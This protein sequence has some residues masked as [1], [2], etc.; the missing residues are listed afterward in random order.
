M[1]TPKTMYASGQSAAQCVRHF[2]KNVPTAGE[3]IVK[4]VPENLSDKQSLREMDSRCH[5][6][7]EQWFG[8]F[9]E[10]FAKYGFEYESTDKNPTADEQQ[11]YNSLADLKLE[12]ADIKGGTQNQA[13]VRDE[14]EL[15]NLDRKLR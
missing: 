1:A 15:P 6:P 5:E 14:R 7:P 9:S 4:E 12:G 3:L 11:E 10:R 2:N 8:H 13:P